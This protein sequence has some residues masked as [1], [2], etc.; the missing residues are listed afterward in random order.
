MLQLDA[1][2]EEVAA[3]SFGGHPLEQITTQL[4]NARVSWSSFC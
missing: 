1:T 2:G 3:F 4:C